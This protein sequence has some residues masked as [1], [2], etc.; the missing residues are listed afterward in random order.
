MNQ[1]DQATILRMVSEGKITPEEAAQLLEALNES[2]RANIPPAPPTPPTPPIPPRPPMPPA[3]APGKGKFLRV[4]VKGIDP[5][6]GEEIDVDV[7]VPM[8]LARKLTPML[9]KMIPENAQKHMRESGVEIAMILA[10]LESIDEDM[11]GRD[12]VNVK[13]GDGTDAMWV[14][15]YVE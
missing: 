9:D 13:I 11:E 14:R 7:N 8:K 2:E 3:A 1:L 12:I 15:V 4:I 10:M 5:D 6:K